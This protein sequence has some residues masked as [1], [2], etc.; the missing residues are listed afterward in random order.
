[1]TD[2]SVAGAGMAGLVAAARL[3][4]LGRPVVVREKGTRVGGSMLLS[5]CVVF[6]HRD[7]AEFRAECPGGDEALQR[8]VWERLD[9]AIAWLVARGAPVV[10]EETG[11]P[12]TVG[13][14]F[15]PRGV[16]EALGVDVVLG[17]DGRV[18]GPLILC[19]GGFAASP[20]LVTRHIAPA[21]PLRLRANPWSAGDGL[22][23]ALERGGA[24]TGG[25]SDFYGRNMPDAAW[26]ETELVSLSQLYGRFA[27][28]FDEDGVEFFARDQVSWS[29]TNVVAAT[30]KRPGAKAYY[31]LDEGALGERVRDRTVADMVAAAP[32][33]SR[34]ALP[35]LPFA[36]PD[37]AVAAV[38]VIASITHTIG[39]LRVDERARVLRPDGSAVPDLWAAGVDAG[40]VA[41]GGYASGLAQALVLGLAAAED[42]ART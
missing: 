18:D 19:T 2:V 12:R 36:P 42:A 6:R 17:A 38:R 29:E 37:G 11:N 41:T 15:D 25:M 13:K 33:E 10:W 24:L 8:L 27:R 34:V 35:D 28:I 20:E 4:E 14:R 22:S 3:R 16:V 32:A 5:S 23:L 1:V 40:G 9:D 30:A 21:A 39:G 26:D 7:F 31:V